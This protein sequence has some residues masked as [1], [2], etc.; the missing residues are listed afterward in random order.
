MI[1]PRKLFA[2]IDYQI[3]PSYWEDMQTSNPPLVLQIETASTGGLWRVRIC[4]RK[5]VQ[6][7]SGFE[8]KECAEEWIRSESKFWI[9]K[10][11]TAAEHL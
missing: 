9:A 5:R 7:I 11:E 1:N 10:L 8:A 6:L 2:I 4:D 3:H